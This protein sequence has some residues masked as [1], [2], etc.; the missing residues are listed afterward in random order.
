MAFNSSENIDLDDNSL[1][2]RY[3][4]WVVIIDEENAIV[5]NNNLSSTIK[6]ENEAPEIKEIDRRYPSPRY[7][8]ESTEFEDSVCNFINNI[9]FDKVLECFLIPINNL[10][11]YLQQN[12]EIYETN[13]QL[14]IV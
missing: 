10:V 11:I 8:L 13:S 7:D 6:E 3:V 5:D 14:E 2:K 1:R 12:I 4:D 9:D